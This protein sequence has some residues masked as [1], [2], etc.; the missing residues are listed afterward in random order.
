MQRQRVASKR[1]RNR[2][3]VVAVKAALIEAPGDSAHYGDF[4]EPGDHE[5]RQVV[6]LAAPS[7]YA[8]RQSCTK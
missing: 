4:A 3:R 6:E 1:L 7:I 5:G 8:P 2:F